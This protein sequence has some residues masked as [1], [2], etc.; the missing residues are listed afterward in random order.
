MAH[1]DR[2]GDGL[3][4]RRLVGI[5][6]GVPWPRSPIPHVAMIARA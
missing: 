1:A 2:P 6:V 3:A 4:D 5:A